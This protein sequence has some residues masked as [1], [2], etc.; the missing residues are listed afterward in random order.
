MSNYNTFETFAFATSNSLSSDDV[1]IQQLV[2]SVWFY[3]TSELTENSGYFQK[4]SYIGVAPQ[5]VTANL[6]TYSLKYLV[7]DDNSKM[8]E[9]IY[10]KILEN[11]TGTIIEF[12]RENIVTTVTETSKTEVDITIDLYF[13]TIFK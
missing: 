10:A 1:S 13:V 3:P 6:D 9:E 11:Y 5:L 7:S 4:E 8:K 12:T 2:R